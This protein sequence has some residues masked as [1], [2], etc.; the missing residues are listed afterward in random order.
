MNDLGRDAPV[1]LFG[2]ASELAEEGWRH[3]DGDL[4]P[5]V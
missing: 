4:V 5:R 2:D 3:S 1:F